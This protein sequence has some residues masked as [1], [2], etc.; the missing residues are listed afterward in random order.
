MTEAQRAILEALM[1][2]ARLSRR[3]D[4]RG[5]RQRW[6]IET[7][8]G[9]DLRVNGSTAKSLIRRGWISQVPLKLT[10]SR[11]SGIPFQITLLGSEA[12]GRGCP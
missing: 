1:A 11:F 10:E 6:T 12:L 8:V 3:E 5:N 9:A 7:D 2:G 4:Y